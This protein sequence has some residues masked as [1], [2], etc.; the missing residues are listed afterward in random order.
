V[1]AHHIGNAVNQLGNIAR[2][3]AVDDALHDAACACWRF[4]RWF[5]DDRAA[6]S[7]RRSHFL[8][9]QIDREIPR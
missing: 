7:E 3:A 4:F 6:R 2:N 8:A 5:G 1:A 9:H